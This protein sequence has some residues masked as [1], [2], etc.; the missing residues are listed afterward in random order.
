MFFPDVGDVDDWVLLGHGDAGIKS[1]PDKISSVGGSVIMLANKKTEKVCVLSWR[2]KK[3]VRKVISS[4]AGE[5]LAM[6]DTIGEVVYN[7]AILRQ[8]Y[9]PRVDSVP[10]II[11]TDSNNLYKAVY[12]TSLVEDARLIPDI[13][14]AQEAIEQGI[15]ME[16]R[17]VEGK[18][19]IANCLTKAGASSEHL[20]QVLQTGL[21]EL[22]GGFEERRKEL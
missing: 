5:A 12:S 19:M 4:L 13:A 9:G 16:V 22:P 1:L 8:I 14:V 10:V 18:E 7:K 11:L 3:L 15:V 20:M 21:Y 17:K 2:S 6:N